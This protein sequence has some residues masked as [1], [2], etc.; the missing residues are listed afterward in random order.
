MRTALCKAVVSL[1][2]LQSVPIWHGEGT[3]F[4]CVGG[5]KNPQRERRL[6]NVKERLDG[7]FY[8]SR[9][10]VPKTSLCKT[11]KCLER[12]ISGGLFRT[13]FEKSLA[14]KLFRSRKWRNKKETRVNTGLFL[15]GNIRVFTVRNPRR[16]GKR[17][18]PV[19]L[20]PK[21]GGAA[22]AAHR[23]RIRLSPWRIL[24][25]RLRIFQK[26]PYSL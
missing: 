10:P 23:R 25:R 3:T 8:C 18:Q 7:C 21:W 15:I 26:H 13:V 22:D 9:C 16:P 4:A 5:W 17:V 1:R 14:P 11:T 6:V 24:R 12:F 19:C 2:C 20:L